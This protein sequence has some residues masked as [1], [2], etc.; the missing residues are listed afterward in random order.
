MNSKGFTL[1]ELATIVMIIG[2]LALIAIPN[3]TRVTS[4][5]KEAAI[6]ENC[7]TIQVA[8]EDFALQNNGL[9]AENV[10]ADITPGGSTLIDLLPSGKRLVNPF[11]Q[12]STEPSDGAVTNPGEIGYAPV[13]L[14]RINIG[15]TITAIGRKP[16]API[17]ALMSGQ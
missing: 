4:Q 5:A 1:I 10:D 7:H 11:T 13:K 8:A 16:N 15:Y 2:I 6:K 9:Y 3:F 12:G 14:N 17:F